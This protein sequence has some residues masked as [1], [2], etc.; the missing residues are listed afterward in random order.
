MKILENKAIPVFSYACMDRGS[1]LCNTL[2]VFFCLLLIL[3]QFVLKD[4][5]NCLFR[6]C[7]SRRYN[8][9]HI[10]HRV[11]RSCSVDAVG[12]VNMYTIHGK[13]NR[14]ERYITGGNTLHGT[15]LIYSVTDHARDGGGHIIQRILHLTHRSTLYIEQS[16]GHPGSGCNR[17]AAKRRQPSEVF[18][19]VRADQIGKRIATAGLRFFQGAGF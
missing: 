12:P 9:A 7:H 3:F 16:A 13:F 14:S 11:F 1:G 2:A 10:A 6:F 18:L 5:H 19:H 17:A 8:Q 15:S 4:L